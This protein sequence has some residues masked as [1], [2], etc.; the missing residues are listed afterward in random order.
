VSRDQADRWRQNGASL[1]L[2]LPIF[3]EKRIFLCV[4]F[5]PRREAGDVGIWGGPL[6]EASSRTCHCRFFDYGSYQFCARCRNRSCMEERKK[7]SLLYARLPPRG[8]VGDF[9]ISG[10]GR[11]LR[12]PL[13]LVVARFLIAVATDSCALAVSVRISN[14]CAH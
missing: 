11:S 8:E 13:K 3:F 4:R 5:P 9:R 7:E 10:G 14:L 1:N 2:T 6:S 12:P